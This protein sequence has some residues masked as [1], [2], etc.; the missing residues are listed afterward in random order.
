VIAH[1]SDFLPFCAVNLLFFRAF[2][3]HQFSTIPNC[4]FFGYLESHLLNKYFVAM[5]ASVRHVFF[6]QYYQQLPS[7]FLFHNQTMKSLQGWLVMAYLI[8]NFH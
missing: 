5:L 8:G 2:T 1:F 6:S 4:A 7:M 3:H